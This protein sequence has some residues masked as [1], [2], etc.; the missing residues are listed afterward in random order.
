MP[1]S[2]NIPWFHHALRSV[3]AQSLSNIEVVITDDSGGELREVVENF[4]DLRIRYYPN[5]TRLGFS[6]NHCRAIELAQGQY[7][8][9][10]HDDDQW[11][12]EYL[13]VAVDIMDA[14]P[15]VGLVLC[16]AVEVDADDN[17]LGARPA[18]MDPGLQ[19][20]PLSNFLSS[21][22]MMML[23]SLSVFR[24]TALTS[25]R[26]PWPD[27]IA[28]D[29]TMFIDVTRAGWQTYHVAQPLVR[30]RVH[31]HQI[32]TDDLAHRHA[33]VTV[34][35]GYT[36]AEERFERARMK[37]LASSFIAR[38]G[39]LLKRGHPEAARQDL[40][41]A[42]RTSPES[43]GMRWWVLQAATT[44]PFLVPLLLKVRTLLPRRDRHNGV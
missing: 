17:V 32:G 43:V 11:E 19:T 9:I 30:Y 36:F 7:L 33:L 22:C 4:D 5:P 10:L 16:G 44:A 35:S 34:W 14:R 24:T 12:P 6:G 28:A 18:K 38:A 25:N 39:A 3:L 15:D 13:A 1:A 41:E 2:R 40:I 29:M 26:R 27:V 37:T 21:G 8:A 31:D 23:P 42:R 20:D